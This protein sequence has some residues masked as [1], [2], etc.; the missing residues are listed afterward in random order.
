MASPLSTIYRAIKMHSSASFHLGLCAMGF[1]TSTM[2]VVFATVSVKSL[3][4]AIILQQ[5]KRLRIFGV[6][7]RL[8]GPVVKMSATVL[9]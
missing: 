2:W 4:E 7:L 1:V 9:L 5:C 6:F 8:D 3:P